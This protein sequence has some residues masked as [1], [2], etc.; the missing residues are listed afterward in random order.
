[1]GNLLDGK[2]AIVTGSGSGVG[3]V[4][5]LRFAEEGARVVCADIR[6][7]QVK[8][9]VSLIEAAGGTATAVGCDVSNEDDVVAMIAAAVEAYGRLDILFSNVGIPT[10][11]LGSTLEDHTAE[12]FARLVGV[13]F[14]GVFFGTKH[15]IIQF[16]RQGGGGVILNTGSVAGLVSW[17]G[18]VYGATKGAVHQLT[19][20]AAIE[21]APFGIRAN[22]ICP[23]GMPYTNFMAAGG[24]T[25]PADALDQAA[26][27]VGKSHPLGRPITAEDC[28]EAAVFLVSDRAANVTG[29]LLPVDGGYVAR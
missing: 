3:R 28:A 1:M 12:D 8:E 13:N 6:L 23:A 4:S 24:M 21:G 2:S 17:G 26:A 20:A 25:L 18:S 15:A 16:K 5:A 11:R 22:A 19:K 29:V 14:G 7:E 27:Q 10:P 9:T